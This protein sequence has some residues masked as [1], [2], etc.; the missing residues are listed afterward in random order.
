MAAL[1]RLHHR[2]H[3]H[4]HCHHCHCHCHCHHTPFGTDQHH[5]DGIPPCLSQG[6]EDGPATVDL[7]GMPP[8]LAELIVASALSALEKR[9]A[10]TGR[11]QVR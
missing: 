8:A 4:C 10:R 11:C 7:R 1:H 9:A 5:R 6:V 3:C 2:H